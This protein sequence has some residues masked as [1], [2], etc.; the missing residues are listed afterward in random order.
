M[1]PSDATVYVCKLWSE[2]FLAQTSVT[3]L[4]SNFSR[5]LPISRSYLQCHH[6]WH[7]D[8]FSWQD[9]MIPKQKRKRDPKRP[10]SKWT[11]TMNKFENVER[12]IIFEMMNDE[13][14]V[15]NGMHFELFL[16]DE[17]KFQKIYSFQ[18]GEDDVIF[19]A[20][21]SVKHA[22][23]Q[24]FYDNN[25]V[26][27][28]RRNYRSWRRCI[29]NPASKTMAFSIVGINHTAVMN[30]KNQVY[31]NIEL[32]ARHGQSRFPEYRRAH[33]STPTSCYLVL[34]TRFVSIADGA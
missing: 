27:N 31:L 22:Q 15:E 24:F 33:N 30:L 8:T 29:T 34:H 11:A 26:R 19:E 25:L 5:L 14:A 2:K 28:E 16:V 10:I 21:S 9:L 12:R 18:Q 6:C 23:N 20:I 3:V 17:I 13:I 32:F 1:P 4:F 7:L